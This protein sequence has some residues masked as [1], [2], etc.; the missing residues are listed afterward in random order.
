MIKVLIVEDE[1]LTRQG[2]IMTV[3]WEKLG[4]ELIGDAI[5]GKDGAEKIRKFHP[6]LVITDIR[7]PVMSGLDMMKATRNESECFYVILSGYDEFRYCQEAMRLGAKDYLLKPID[8][9]EFAEVITKNVA[10]LEKRHHEQSYIGMSE[11]KPFLNIYQ[12]KYVSSAYEIIRNRYKED[13][14]I[15]D[16]ADTLNISDSYLEKLIRTKTNYT[17]RGLLT[18]FRIKAA[19]TLLETTDLKVY[20]IANEVGYI[21]SKYFS[22]IF[23]KLVGIKPTEY[24]KGYRLSEDNI[25]THLDDI[26]NY[27]RMV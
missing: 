1:K 3:D 19:V 7:M 24:R 10:L 6:D 17:F 13:L 5:N 14:T 18:L 27:N 11:Q 8:D 15:R 12:N 4:C 20:T 25:L 16:V 21:D 22:K 2:L 26:N 23:Q 9:S